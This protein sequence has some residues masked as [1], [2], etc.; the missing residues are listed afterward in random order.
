MKYMY[1][2]KMNGKWLF[3]HV[4]NFSTAKKLFSILLTS[5]YIFSL[6][7]WTRHK[8]QIV[9]K[10]YSE[11]VGIF[12]TDGQYNWKLALAPIF[13]HSYS[14]MAE[15]RNLQFDFIPNTPFTILK[16]SFQKL[17]TKL[18]LSICRYLFWNIKCYLKYF[19]SLLS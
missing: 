8:C 17:V 9:S 16:F 2:C 15:S 7:I 5:K 14:W 6:R 3:S 4:Q 19:Y 13:C 10:Q 1:A 18:Q 12:W 11:S